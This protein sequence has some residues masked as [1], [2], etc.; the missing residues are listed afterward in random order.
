MKKGIMRA[1]LNAPSTAAR[2]GTTGFFFAP[3]LNLPGAPS[4]TGVDFA[5]DRRG[6]LAV[7]VVTFALPWGGMSVPCGHSGGWERQDKVS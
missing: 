4:L 3:G 6:E 7:L 5:R 2:P 1:H